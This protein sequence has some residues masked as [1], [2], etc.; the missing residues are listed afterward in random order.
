[1]DRYIHTFFHVYD[2]NYPLE[3]HFQK[4]LNHVG[5]WL[6]C[7]N[8]NS[9]LVES[10]ELVIFWE[11]RRLPKK[12]LFDKFKVVETILVHHHQD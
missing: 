6:L 3:G 10:G 12:V 5:V 9:Q 8:A 1:M 4:A 7:K 2:F 11:I